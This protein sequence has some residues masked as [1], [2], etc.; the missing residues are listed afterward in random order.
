MLNPMISNY[1]ELTVVDIPAMCFC[2]TY[3]FPLLVHYRAQ[4]IDS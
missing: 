2:E 1:H 4:K 3:G